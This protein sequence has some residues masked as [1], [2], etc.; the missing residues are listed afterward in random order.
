MSVGLSFYGTRA[1]IKG[2]SERPLALFVPYEVMMRRGA[3]LM[4][5]HVGILILDFQ[6]L[7]CEK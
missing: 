2:T 7:N 4:L 6:L 3:P 1:H 5:H